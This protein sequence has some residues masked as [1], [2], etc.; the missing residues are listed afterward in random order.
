MRQPP[1]KSSNADGAGH[2]LLD[3][4]TQASSAARSG[5]NHRPR[6][7]DFGVLARDVTCQTR[8]SGSRRASADHHAPRAAR[9]A[10]GASQIC[11]RRRRRPALR[12]IQTADAVR[13]RD[14]GEAPD[15]I[16]DRHRDAIDG[17]RSA[18]L[19]RDLDVSGLRGPFSRRLR[20][21]KVVRRLAQRRRAPPA[22]VRPHRLPSMRNRPVDGG[23]GM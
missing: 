1:L 20:R 18:A 2:P 23:S 14:R 17:G 8:R 6:W 16:E 9:R 15:Q 19:E 21:G 7:I 11:A 4:S 5:A 12:R 10:A 22:I 13:A 3:V